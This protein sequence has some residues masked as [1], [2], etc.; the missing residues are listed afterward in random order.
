[1]PARWIESLATTEP[2]AE[3]F[4]DESVLRAMLTFETALARAEARVGVIPQ[5]AAEAIESAAGAGDFNMP[6][7]ARDT[8][9]AGTPGIPLVKALTERV[10]A[11]NE[12][13][14]RFVHWGATSQDVADTA[15]MLLLRQAQHVLELDYTRLGN[16]LTKM[17]REHRGTV[18]LGRTLLQAAPPITLGLKAAGWLAAVRRCW[19]RLSRAFSEALILQ[20]GGASGTLAAL[21]NKGTEIS[22]ALAE[23]LGLGYP[24]A[25]WHTHRDRLASLVAGLGVLTGSLGKMARDIALLMQTEVGEAAEPGGGGRG[26]SS[27]MPHK[28]NP[29]A[30]SLTLAAA[31]QTPGLVAA[32]LTAMIQEHERG[33]G[34]WQSEWPTVVG[35]VQSTGLALASMAEAADGLTIDESRMRANIASTRGNI[36]AERAMILLGAKLGRDVAH[37]IVQQAV[38]RSIIESRRLVEVLAEMPEI[39]ALVPLDELRELERPEDYL[40]S[41][42][43]F[44][45][46]LTSPEED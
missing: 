30:C 17:S 14:A 46:R 18:M 3:L 32:F 41:A 2:L 19:T 23:E 38:Q 20:F 26:G 5:S 11:S 9:R 33:V 15:L 37:G 31:N 36:F 40:G 13:A 10:R 25:P 34:G 27:T 24:D 8:F 4:S 12:E 16:A 6:E 22:R 39:T 45:E 28:Q 29:I 44:R 21:G 35:V 1:M 7:L 42:N 43:E